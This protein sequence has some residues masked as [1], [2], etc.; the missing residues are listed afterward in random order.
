MRLIVLFAV[1]AAAYSQCA[2]CHEKENASEVNSI[3][4]QEGVGCSDCHGGNPKAVGKGSA[5]ADSFKGKFEKKDIVALCGNCHS[6]VRK[7]NPYGLPTDQVAQ[8]WTS[9]H[10]ETLSSGNTDVA[11][12][13]D[14]HGSHGQRKVRDP[15]SPVYPK[16]VPATCGR[17]HSNEK[18]MSD[19]DLPSNP[20]E[21]YRQSY[22]AEML[23][24]KDDL[25][26]PTCVTCH[27]NHGAVPP[28]FTDIAHVCGKCHIKQ[29][30]LFVES[31]HYKLTQEGSFKGCVTCHSNHKVLRTPDEILK[32][33]KVCHEDGDKGTATRIAVFSVIGTTE[34]DYKNTRERL[35]KFAQAGFHV[36]DEEVMIE[37]AKTTMLQLAPAQ[38][39]LNVGSVKKLAMATEETLQDIDK[40]LDT[41]EKTEWYKKL[42]LVPVWI[43]LISMSV[44][45][46]KKRKQVEGNNVGE[47]K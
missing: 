20:E 37:E 19:H 18:L 22:H 4:H 27:G 6:D 41:K 7:M 43:F 21:L 14:C 16:N 8:Y 39:T 10:G 47:N 34:Q 11:V 9:K 32:K 25:S 36:D 29:Q 44:I 40:R 28:G 42:A 17:C 2:N 3:H 12:C 38:H 24:K 33:C 31:P 35:S 30:G 1:A 46:Y 5:H 15:Q 23:L 13:S 26:A 45:F